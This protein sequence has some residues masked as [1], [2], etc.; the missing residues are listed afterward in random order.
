MEDLMGFCNCD[1]ALMHQEA[2]CM[3]TEALERLW[4]KHSR[5]LDTAT[6]VRAELQRSS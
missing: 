2:S 3:A 5:K 4:Q 6:T 1:I